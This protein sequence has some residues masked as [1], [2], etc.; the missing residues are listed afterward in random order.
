MSLDESQ[1][2]LTTAA[3]GTFNGEIK[4]GL[5]LGII[6][7]QDLEIWVVAEEPWHLPLNTTNSV[8][9]VNMVNAGDIFGSF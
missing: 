4:M 7:S 2:E 5:G 1:V 6:G 3:D 9:M 8:F